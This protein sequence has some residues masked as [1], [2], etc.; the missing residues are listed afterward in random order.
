MNRSRITPLLFLLIVLIKLS[1]FL[2][3]DMFA[4]SAAERGTQSQTSVKDSATEHLP[5]FSSF[6]QFALHLREHTDASAKTIRFILEGEP[7]SM[8]PSDVYDQL[9][10]LMSSVT[11][12]K[13]QYRQ[14]RSSR[15][16]TLTP[17]Y[18]LGKRMAYA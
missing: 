18:Y 3:V 4:P 5:R 6:D 10:R 13:V 11:S 17:T 12:F 9:Y 14:K 16:M 8:T 7:T 15:V 1:A 2:D